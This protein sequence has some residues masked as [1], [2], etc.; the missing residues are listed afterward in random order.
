MTE[1]YLAIL[2]TNPQYLD[3]DY[4]ELHI[5]GTE[6]YEVEGHSIRVSNGE[7]IDSL[8]MNIGDH[9]KMTQHDILFEAIDT[10]HAEGWEISETAYSQSPSRDNK[11]WSF[12]GGAWHVV[13]ENVYALV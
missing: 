1:K 9:D 10:L 8:R 13:I 11:E 2:I 12:I 7:S 3:T 5:T 6:T 4:Y